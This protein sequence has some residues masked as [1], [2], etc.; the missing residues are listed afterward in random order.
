M[1]TRVLVAPALAAL[2][3]S[4]ALLA[5]CGDDGNGPNAAP[6][7]VLVEAPSQG[8]EHDY[9]VHLA[10]SG[11]DPDGEVVGY[12]V[13]WHDGLVYSG[14]FD[15]LTWEWTDSDEDSFKVAADSCPTVGSTCRGSHT[16]FVRAVDNG[17][18]RDTT[19]AHVSFTATTLTPKSNITDPPRAPGHFDVTVP[20]CMKIEWTGTDTDGEIVKYRYA[21]KKYWDPPTQRPPDPEDP[22]RWSDWGTATE[23][24]LQMDPT[25][26][27]DPWSFYVQAMDNSGAL[28][29][30][31]LD[32]KNHVVVYVDESMNSSPYIGI[33]CW[34][35]KCSAAGRRSLGSRSTQDTTA[36]NV[37]IGVEVGDTVCFKVAALPGGLA[38][39]I[40]QIAYVK[41]PA[42]PDAM[43]GNWTS[44][45]PSFCFPADG[46]GF[47]VSPSINVFYVWVRDDYCEFGNLRRAHIMINGL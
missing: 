32:G 30:T 10:W 25:D 9:R 18:A 13:S 17:G 35:G 7:T 47:I 23:T 46:V 11:T 44:Y 16:F 3:L 28:E 26:P 34:R 41:N 8:S 27:D 40:T 42:D 21:M 12:E 19:P 33:G 45:S 43:P 36:M 14:T 29:N 20:T 15:D 37:P 22:S 39:E 6:E 5:S 1:R 24:T 38:D 2:A 31:F 4:L